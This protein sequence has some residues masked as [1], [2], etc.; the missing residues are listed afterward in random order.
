MRAIVHRE[1]LSAARRRT[2]YVFRG[3][4]GL[5]GIAMAV[6]GSQF[7]EAMNETGRFIFIS[8]TIAGAIFAIRAGAVRAA[9][10]LSEERAN[11]TLGLLFLTPL[12]SFDVVMGKFVSASLLAF[13]TV[14]VLAPMLAISLL[15][16]GVSIHEVLRAAL[17][18]ANVTF[19]FVTTSLFISSFTS[20]E[21]GSIVL[22]LFV[23]LSMLFFAYVQLSNNWLVLGALNFEL[24]PIS[25][26]LLINDRDFRA[27]WF[28]SGLICGH[29]IGWM[30]LW[31]TAA[32]LK[33][34]WQRPNVFPKLAV[35]WSRPPKAKKSRSQ[36]RPFRN[37]GPIE[38]LILRDVYEGAPLGIVLICIVVTA[39]LWRLYRD[40]AG[41][42]AIFGLIPIVFGVIVHSAV[43]TARARK[44]GVLELVSAAPISDH[45]I[46]AG[47]IRGLRRA[48]LL[49][50]VLALVCVACFL[51]SWRHTYERIDWIGFEAVRPHYMILVFLLTLWAAAYTGIW[52]ALKAK[53]PAG[54]VFC[55]IVFCLILPWVLPMPAALY[56]Y[57]LGH[58]ARQTVRGEYR[59]LLAGR[60]NPPPPFPKIQDEG[61]SYSQ[62]LLTNPLQPAR[63]PAG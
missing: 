8:I 33:S 15:F 60:T 54:A 21:L 51:P 19:F 63:Q 4:V 31:I 34:N 57:M 55:N 58:I 10:T 13:Q 23:F 24:N 42:M 35:L 61:D 25:I 29:L 22:A 44:A 18:I 62:S 20:S 14:L 9:T 27:D 32:I 26:G 41:I 40:I 1:M 47:Q 16:G 12:K 30:V 38:W 39:S 49:P 50:A 46:V 45:E 43:A 48:F 36:S 6:M 11:G 52:T 56:L 2:T 59:A 28:W 7:S 5:F 37:Q 53:G 3:I 17:W